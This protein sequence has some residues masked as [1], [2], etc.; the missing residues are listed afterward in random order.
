[1][2][3]LQE[4]IR[5]VKKQRKM[6]GLT[7]AELAEMAGIS[8]ST[9]S[10]LETGRTKKPAPET[11]LALQAAL[12]YEVAGVGEE[13]F[14]F[15]KD[16]HVQIQKIAYDLLEGSLYLVF[17]LMFERGYIYIDIYPFGRED[18]QDEMVQVE[19]ALLE[20]AKMYKDYIEE[21][22]LED[23]IPDLVDDVTASSLTEDEAERVMFDVIY[24]NVIYQCALVIDSGIA[25]LYEM[26]SIQLRHML[27]ANEEGSI[28]DYRKH[29]DNLIDVLNGGL[30]LGMISDCQMKLSLSN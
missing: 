11:V 26:V 19:M 14:D 30:K 22:I 13:I 29:L 3:E 17:E 27:E 18:D 12:A 24:K 6:A 10:S 4:F 8:A 9:L 20:E 28:K 23:L 15:D 16:R 2:D 1:M 5:Y 21:R 7:Q 25:E